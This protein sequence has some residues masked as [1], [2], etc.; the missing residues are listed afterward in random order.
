MEKNKDPLPDIMTGEQ[1][2]L[3]WAKKQTRPQTLEIFLTDHGEQKGF[4]AFGRSLSRLVPAIRIKPSDKKNFLPGFLLKANIIYSAL[5]LDKELSPFLRGLSCIQTRAPKPSKPVQALLE[6]ITLPC[7]LTLYIA[8]QC[9]HCP[10]VVNTILPLAVFSDKIHLKIIDGTLFPEAAQ[11][12][13]VLS[14][15]CLILDNGFRWTGAVT[16]EEV[17]SMAVQQ[18]AS[19]LSSQT[20]KTILEQGDADWISREMIQAGTVFKEFIPLLIHD[21][22]SVRLGAMVVVETLAQE[23]P[24]VAVQLCP[25]LIQEFDHKEIPVQGDI[26]YALG[27]T[28][29]LET[30]A[31]L[32]KKMKDLE[33][34]DLKEAAQDAI[35]AIE[36]RYA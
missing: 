9:P 16:A 32:K 31:W 6:Q 27:E 35:E 1:T 29:S 11:K 36:S 5:A 13:K 30:K 26:L 28:G 3:A 34:G 15:P 23:R 18:D 14:A 4:E 12:D 7:E 33:D 2:I 8:L 21:T 24:D 22:W 20:L 17:L 19:R 25:Q 10:G